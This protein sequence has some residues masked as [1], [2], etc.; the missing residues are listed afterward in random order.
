MLKTIL[1][2]LVVAVSTL[3]LGCGADCVECP[4]DDVPVSATMLEQ[5][6]AEGTCDPDPSEPNDGGGAVQTGSVCVRISNAM[7]LVKVF[8][9]RYTA[10]GSSMMQV[11]ASKAEVQPGG[12]HEVCLPSMAYGTAGNITVDA[13]DTT[14]NGGYFWASSFT[15]YAMDSTVT[16]VR[17]TLY[18]YSNMAVSWEPPT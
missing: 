6:T 4:T 12:V 17:F 8:D 16:P 1:Y 10:T 7:G 14:A 3:T 5:C 13:W 11:A 2:P 15:T 18:G 9:V